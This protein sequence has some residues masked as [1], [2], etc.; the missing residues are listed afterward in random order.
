MKVREV[1]R[2]IADDGWYLVA[3]R[4]VTDSSSIR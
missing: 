1:N 4:A 3:T 2:V